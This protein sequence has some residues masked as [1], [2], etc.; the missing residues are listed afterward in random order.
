VDGKP[1]KSLCL[2]L[3]NNALHVGVAKFSD[4]KNNFHRSKG[5][6]IAQ[7]R[8]ELAADVHSGRALARTKLKRRE[9]LSFSITITEANP[10]ESVIES[11]LA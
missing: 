7:G 1:T 2:I 5:R 3:D 10:F 8:A 4:K 9:E 6:V 11:L